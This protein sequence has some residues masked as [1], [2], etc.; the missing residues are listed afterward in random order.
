MVQYMTSQLRVSWHCCLMPACTKGFCARNCRNVWWFPLGGIY[1]GDRGQGS[2][3]VGGPFGETGGEQRG[4][5]V[6]VLPGGACRGSDKPVIG[7]EQ[8]MR[9]SGRADV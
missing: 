9:A 1:R 6:S 5:G 8:H 2:V 3:L 7:C 4:A